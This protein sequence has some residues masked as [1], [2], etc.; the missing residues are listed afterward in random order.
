M[1]G[2]RGKGDIDTGNNNVGFRCVISASDW[3]PADLSETQN[4]R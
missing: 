1:M 3:K 4:A 2:T